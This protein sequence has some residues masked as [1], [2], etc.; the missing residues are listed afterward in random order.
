MGKSTAPE[1]DAAAGAEEL[2]SSEMI[3]G[4][5]NSASERLPRLKD[6][7]FL[8]G[9]DAPGVKDA[10]ISSS[11][12]VDRRYTV[13]RWQVARGAVTPA[14]TAT[15]VVKSVGAELLQQKGAHGGSGLPAERSTH[16]GERGVGAESANDAS[17]AEES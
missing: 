10:V 12:L 2:R 9:V 4:S 5:K 15:K 17:S 11:G 13:K 6:F 3:T 8:S 16:D 14:V 7:H 1:A